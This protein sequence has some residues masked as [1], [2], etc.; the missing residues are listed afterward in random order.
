MW[1]ECC[2]SVVHRC[3]DAFA[4]D[5][6]SQLPFRCLR[7]RIRIRP[8]IRYAHFSFSLTLQV[9]EARRL[10]TIFRTV[11]HFTTA[12]HCTCT[13][14]LYIEYVLSPDILHYST[15]SYMRVRHGSVSTSTSTSVSV[16]RSQLCSALQVH[17]S[18][19]HL[20]NFSFCSA[21]IQLSPLSSPLVSRSSIGVESSRALAAATYIHTHTND[22]SDRI[23]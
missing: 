23:L 17:C 12:L 22:T 19:P 18:S 20:L 6:Q 21:L 9:A 16:S 3:A 10:H 1:C 13:R 15:V 5:S 14:T 7:I 2:A 11:L 8:N 4:T